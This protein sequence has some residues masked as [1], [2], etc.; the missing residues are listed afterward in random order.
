[1]S[2]QPGQPLQKKTDGTTVNPADGVNTDGSQNVQLTGSNVVNGGQV[3]ATMYNSLGV[4]TNIGQYAS[5]DTNGYTSNLLATASH[6]LVY[7][8]SGNYERWRN[9]TEGTLLA[10]AARTA[11]TTSATQTNHNARGIIVFLNISVSGGTGGLQLRIRVK[12]PVTGA[13]F[14]VNAAPTLLIATGYYAFILYP[15]IGATVGDV[16]QTT[17]G[18]LGRTW[19]ILVTHGDATSYTYNV[20]YQ[21]I[22]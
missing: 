13:Y 2:Y 12:D 21:L 15:G 4:E 14:S 8:G 9:N 17:S 3:K 19:D 5:I 7:N 22:L 1:M 20:G 10:N 16:T 6:Q 11:T 18:V